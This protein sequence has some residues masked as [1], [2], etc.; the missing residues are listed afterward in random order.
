[1]KRRGFI[2][3]ATTLAVAAVWRS[4][5][6]DAAIGGMDAGAANEAAALA[7][8]LLQAFPQRQSL[9]VIGAAYRRDLAADTIAHD[10]HEARGGCETCIPDAFQGFLR[11]LDLTK[12]DLRDMTPFAMRRRIDTETAR[13]FSEGRIISVEGWLLGETEARLCEIAALR[14]G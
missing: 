4:K 10:T 8:H 1:M 11:H 9:Q 6:A 3:L 13:D 5:A 12:T 2:G 14:T 7:D